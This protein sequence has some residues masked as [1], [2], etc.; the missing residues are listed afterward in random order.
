VY[1]ITVYRVS[2]IVVKVAG[3]RRRTME[4][5]FR[6]VL[7]SVTYGSLHSLAATHCSRCRRK[8][9]RRRSRWRQASDA[10]YSDDSRWVTLKHSLLIISR[11]PHSDD[12]CTRSYLS[13]C[14]CVW[15]KQDIS[16][17]DRSLHAPITC[18]SGND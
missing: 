10:H 1:I 9:R 14:V 8:L 15:C 17:T 4:A 18:Y 7:P 3:R 12:W 13:M 6:P 16:K 2:K 11:Q 5:F